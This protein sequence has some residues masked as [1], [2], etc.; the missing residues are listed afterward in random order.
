MRS[1]VIVEEAKSSHWPISI[2]S[3]M[4]AIASLLI[5]ILLVRILTAEEVGLYKLFFLYVT[6]APVFIGVTGL[7]NALSYFSGNED[8]WRSS[9]HIIGA[10]ILIITGLSLIVFLTSS[11]FLST[12]VHADHH[13]IRLFGIAIFGNAI[14]SFLED[15]LIA[16]AKVWQGA[17]FQGLF[18]FVRIAAMILAALVVGTLYAVLLVYSVSCLLR[19][20]VGLMIGM[21]E[22]YF[23]LSGGLSQ[24]KKVVKYAVPVS[25]AWLF[26]ICITHF[27]QLLLSQLI[28]PREFA[29]YTLGCL[30]V[31]PL[32][33]LERSVTRI[34]IPEL[35]QSF[36]QGDE[37]RASRLF[38]D[39][40]ETLAFF[41]IP[42]ALVL[43]IYSE[44]IIRILFTEEYMESSHFLSWF[45]FSYLFLIFPY[46]SLARARGDSQWILGTL[47]RCALISI[48]L[49]TILTILF[50][51]S[52]ALF[53]LL[54]SSI[55]LRLFSFHYLSESTK[56]PLLAYVPLKELKRYFL[57]ATLLLPFVF[58]SKHLFAS[59]E[60]WFLITSP[61][62]LCTFCIFAR[63]RSH[64]LQ[65]KAIERTRKDDQSP[66]ILTV[67]QNLDM[68]GI[69]R[70]ALSLTDGISREGN[71]RVEVL[72]FNQDP[73]RI[74]EGLLRKFEDR[75]VAVSLFR[76]RPGF[77]FTFVKRLI[78][79]IRGHEHVLLHAHELGGLLYCVFAKVLL[80]GR[81]PIIYTQHSLI[82]LRR[83]WRYR[84]YE[85][86][87]SGFVEHTVAVSD[88]VAE[89][90]QK[91]IGRNNLLSVIPNGVSF[92]ARSTPHRMNEVIQAQELPLPIKEQLCEHKGDVWVLYLARFFP[93][94]GQL[95]ALNLWSALP[96]EVR[97]KIIFLFIGPVSDNNYYQR[98]LVKR[99]E[100][101]DSNR[102]VVGGASREPQELILM[103]D[104]FLSC[105]LYE[106]MPLAPLEALGAGRPTVLSDI[107]GH[108]TFRKYAEIIPLQDLTTSAK[109]LTEIIERVSQDNER[110]HQ[111]SWR[112][113]Q[114]LRDAFSANAM[115]S[116]YSQL[117]RTVLEKYSVPMQHE[118]RSSATVTS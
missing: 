90:Y 76:K 82:H 4:S 36:H 114:P 33:I 91:V 78:Q 44:P 110:L 38:S 24:A 56:L 31:P 118:L 98:F 13:F 104:I 109:A 69:E 46:D 12:F 80:G 115:V 48:P 15:A 99:G 34:L 37:Q 29:V 6:L 63:L 23:G 19:G 32:L 89:K 117:Y 22:H 102:L 50:Q 26:G 97:R 54:S 81:I 108:E 14:G 68:G 87:F 58:L 92:P 9:F 39:A 107:P 2:C 49:C 113:T 55:V 103:S 116:R 96:A 86:L 57:I 72:T 11:H 83:K 45:A 112:L 60:E 59:P 30:S 61:A 16:R 77:S 66:T 18:D 43:M 17:L 62:F 53:G 111:E 41:I 28:T 74:E 65:R 105:S 70:M 88:E 20:V 94:K 93:E 51:A 67:L 85:R 47:V 21:K 71:Y 84:L 101:P 75:S 10:F 95:E 64:P 5:P 3:F 40:I 52:G 27:D 8:A 7:Q 42:S 35:S 73:K 79:Q 100:C 106:G 25:L 1:T